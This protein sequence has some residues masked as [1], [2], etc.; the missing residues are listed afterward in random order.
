MDWFAKMSSTE[1]SDRGVEA[2]EATDVDDAEKANEE[3]DSELLTY[4]D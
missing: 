4:R 3:E 2:A 1:I